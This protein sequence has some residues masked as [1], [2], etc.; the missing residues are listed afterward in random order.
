M[1]Y[2]KNGSH[3]LSVYCWECSGRSMSPR[4]INRGHMTF[5]GDINDKGEKVFTCIK[6][7]YS[8]AYYERYIKDYE[9]RY[10]KRSS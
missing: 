10:K 6:C 9:I 7:Q 5:T 4:K 8:C 1:L 2:D 3:A